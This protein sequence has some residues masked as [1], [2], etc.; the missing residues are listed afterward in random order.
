MQLR[1]KQKLREIYGL[2]ERPFR[3]CVER[4]LHAK[5]VTGFVLLSLLE[6]RLD[7]V[8]RRAGMASSQAQARQ[9]VRH[10][11]VAVNGRVCDIPSRVVREGDLIEV[12]EGSREL[13]SIVTSLA[14]GYE[15]PGWLDVN[16]SALTVTVARLP[17]PEDIKVDVDEQQVVEFYSQ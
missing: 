12:R 10:R 8:L 3:R 4:A 2:L 11:H 14:R 9:V 17:E 16:A 6:R 1:E 7:S 13:Q 5:G 15:V